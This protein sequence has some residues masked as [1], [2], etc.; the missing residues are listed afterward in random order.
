MIFCKNYCFLS[1]FVVKFI[2]RKQFFYRLNFGGNFMNRVELKAA[3]KNQIR[4]KIGIL[5]VITL[6]IALISGIAGAVLSFVPFGGLVASIIITPAFALSIVRVYLNLVKG[7]HPSVEDAF[8][9][10]DDFWAAFKVNFLVGLFTFLWSLLFVIPGIIKAYSY[11][12]SLYI[13]AE[14]KGKP[15]LECI[16]ESM[17]M[18]E[19]H[20]MDLFVLGLSFIGWGLL[21]SITFGIAGIWV[22]PYMQ[23]TYTNVYNSL[24]PVAEAVEQPAIEVE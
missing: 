21:C 19:G 10:F 12:M 24:K 20:K 17:A 5:F 13:L 6:I 4:G 9:G 3:A 18:T 1:K 16:K 7:G 2:C 22:V 23:A 15:A 11:S 14:N 8:C